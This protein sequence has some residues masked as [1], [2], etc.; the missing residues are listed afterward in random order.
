[1]AESTAGGVEGGVARAAHATGVA[2]RKVFGIV[3]APWTEEATGRTRTAPQ[4]QDVL[5]PLLGDADALRTMPK[6]LPRLPSAFRLPSTSEAGR[7]DRFRYCLVVLPRGI[8]QSNSQTCAA[9]LS[10]P[11]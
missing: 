4:Q 9:S 10:Q 3:S 11:E 1:M 2:F 5:S 8:D 7:G 6:P